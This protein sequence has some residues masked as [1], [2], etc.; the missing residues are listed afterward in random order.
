VLLANLLI[1]SIINVPALVIKHFYTDEFT[2]YW[3]AAFNIARLSLFITAAISMVM[4]PEI[5]GEQDHQ[6]KKKI[7]NRAALLV[8]FTS[9]GAAIVF[10]AIPGLLLRILYGPSFEGAVPV[11]EWMG[12]GMIFIGLLQLRVDYFLAQLK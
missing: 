3:T 1:Q 9:L 5:A 10:F 2:G 12:F 4:F 8:L 6:S 11:L 7:F